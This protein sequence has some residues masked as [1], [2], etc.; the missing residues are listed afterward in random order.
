MKLGDVSRPL[1]ILSVLDGTRQ[2]AVLRTPA[3]TS[4]SALP[5][6]L[7]P[8]PFGWS[9]DE[10]YNGGCADMKTPH[11]GWLGIAS[12]FEVAVVQPAG[13]HRMVEGCSMGYEGVVSDVHSWIDAVESVS[14]VDRRRIYACGLSMGGLESLLVAGGHPGLFAATFVFNPIVDPASW[15]EDQLASESVDQR[16]IDEIGGTPSD[17]PAAY[18]RR[19]AFSVL[20]GLRSLPMMIWW[21]SL[22]GIVPRQIERHGKRLYDELKRLDVAT[23]ASEYEHSSHLGRSE[24]LTTDE[25]SA[26]HE[27]SDYEFATR[28]LMLHH[29]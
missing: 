16:L 12:E 8:H 2:H 6:V 7:A 20:P 10:D 28:W 11:R 17:V 21:S 1:E 29:L 25:R 18:A 4:R 26:I 27:T 24:T 22:D 19:S 15:Y 3:T 9:I 23:P 14:R 5:L 13:H